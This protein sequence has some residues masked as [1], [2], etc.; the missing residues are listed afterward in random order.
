[1]SGRLP[2]RG[3]VSSVGPTGVWRP[4]HGPVDPWSSHGLLPRC[5]RCLIAARPIDAP[6]SLARGR[7]GYLGHQAAPPRPTAR[8]RAS[9]LG[10]VVA[11]RQPHRLAAAAAR[12]RPSPLPP[13]PRRRPRSFRCRR[14]CSNEACP[15]RGP[16]P[17]P[18]AATPTPGVHSPMHTSAHTQAASADAWRRRLGPDGDAA[19]A[20]P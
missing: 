14:S 7:C 16:W 9:R 6:F 8:R 10:R 19:R 4:S 13:R 11:S 1:M 20:S 17:S 18:G 12:R 2:F 5:R 3:W 15:R